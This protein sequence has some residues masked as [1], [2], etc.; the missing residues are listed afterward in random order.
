M[1]IVLIGEETTYLS[2]PLNVQQVDKPSKKKKQ[3]LKLTL[4]KKADEE[5]I[6]GEE[7]VVEPQIPEVI[8]SHQSGPLSHEHVQDNPIA[9]LTKVTERTEI[10]VVLPA[11]FILDGVGKVIYND[12]KNDVSYF[13][14]KSA[15]IQM[16]HLM[17]KVNMT[18]DY[19][20]DIIAFRDGTLYSCS[21]FLYNAVK[22]KKLIDTAAKNKNIVINSVTFLEDLIVES[23]E[24][25]DGPHIV[26][27]KFEESWRA[28]FL[29][30]GIIKGVIDYEGYMEIEEIKS[31]IVQTTRT[32]DYALWSVD[33]LT[34]VDNL[35]SQLEIGLDVKGGGFGALH[36]FWKFNF[37]IKK[38]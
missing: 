19:D 27:F 17:K 18:G 22:F 21:F 16:K 7:E 2:T 35:Q 4:K 32:K 37:G 13:T 26:L 3:K 14:G 6:V 5:E 25:Q 24:S 8:R 33:K 11:T 12:F 20:F 38:I 15:T 9:F 31:E 1:S 36:S 28:I 34:V 10:D 23:V 29:N 30:D